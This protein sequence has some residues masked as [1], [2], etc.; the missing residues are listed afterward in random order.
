LPL[1]K[2]HK[3]EVRNSDDD[4]SEVERRVGI[5]LTP[6][7]R[8]KIHLFTTLYANI[9]PLYSPRRSILSKDAR[10]AIESFLS[11]AKR[12][13]KALTPP[14]TD[15]GEFMPRNVNKLFS[16]I[17]KQTPIAQVAL[18]GLLAELVS[19]KAL[20]SLREGNRN[21]RIEPDQW[22]AWACLVTREL[23]SAGLKIAGKSLNKSNSESPYVNVMLAFQSW[24]PGECRHCNSYESMRK[25]AQAASKKFE[26]LREKTLLQIIV[27]WGSQ[28]LQSY[29]GNLMQAPEETVA[30]FDDFAQRILE[31]ARSAVLEACDTTVEPSNGPSQPASVTEEL[32]ERESEA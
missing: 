23:R 18:V 15:L 1:K 29:P 12:L 6:E 14:G 31:E 5:T 27:G 32:R 30:N 13:T 24:L 26:R 22:A 7:T 28:L 21:G 2:S 17:S 4:W 9:G 10:A 3:Y 11:A 8:E 20:D 16:R 19:Q 25:G